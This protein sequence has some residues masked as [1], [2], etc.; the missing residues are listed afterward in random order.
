MPKKSERAN[1]VCR[2]K[3]RR[4][5]FWEN[6][7]PQVLWDSAMLRSANLVWNSTRSGKLVPGRPI[8]SPSTKLWTVGDNHRL[9]PLFEAVRV[10]TPYQTSPNFI[11]QEYI[12]QIICVIA[13]A[14]SNCVLTFIQFLIFN[15]KNT[16]FRS[17][18]KIILFKPFIKSIDINHNRKSCVANSFPF[19]KLNNVSN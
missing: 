8:K 14:I 12:F 15:S 1:W 2:G 9:N 11:Y 7:I 10:Y 13:Y 17:S 19:S 6:I 16:L 5:R 18:L 4:R 3:E